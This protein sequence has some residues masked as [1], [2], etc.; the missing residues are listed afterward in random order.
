M[1]KQ[2]I[3]TVPLSACLHTSA[4]HRTGDIY[5][6]HTAPLMTQHTCLSPPPAPI[7]TLS[8]PSDREEG[9]DNA[10][11]PITRKRWR[12]EQTSGDGRGQEVRKRS[13]CII[14]I[15]HRC[16]SEWFPSSCLSCEDTAAFWNDTDKHQQKRQ[17]PAC[18]LKCD[19][20]D[21]PGDRLSDVSSCSNW[22]SIISNSNKR[23]GATSNLFSAPPSL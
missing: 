16:A 10:H 1:T 5:H 20:T 12:Q 6:C 11:P 8:L 7:R 22:A 14:I 18:K 3:G 4:R 9:R 23:T 19:P 13:G 21:C 15:M 17:I 2:I